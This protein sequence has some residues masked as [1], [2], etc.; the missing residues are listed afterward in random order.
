MRRTGERV[1]IAVTEG[2]VRI[3]SSDDDSMA[4]S[5]GPDALEAVA[6]QQVSYDPHAA[7]LAVVSISPARATSWRDHRLEFVNE[8][9]DVV[10]ANINRYST[11]PLRIADARTGALIFTGTVRPDTLD[12]WLR[13]LDR[14]LPVRVTR[15]AD[16]IT[17]ASSEQNPR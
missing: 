5:T 7:G 13:A 15:T 10:I 4:R 9:L 16:A 3:T 17:L 14:I 6:G 12:G 1:T 8:P 2:R 11:R